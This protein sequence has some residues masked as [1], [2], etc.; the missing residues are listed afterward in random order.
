MKILLLH[1]VTVPPSENV[2][3]AQAWHEPEALL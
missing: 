2:P 3:E 1:E